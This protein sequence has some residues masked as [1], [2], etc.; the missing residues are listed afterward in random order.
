MSRRDRRKSA[1]KHS[2]GLLLSEQEALLDAYQNVKQKEEA[3]A[4]AEK[5]LTAVINY[6]NRDDPTTAF[7]FHSIAGI[8]SNKE[9]VIDA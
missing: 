5:Q 2:F 4:Q 7:V 9:N 3:L 8:A 6:V 1:F